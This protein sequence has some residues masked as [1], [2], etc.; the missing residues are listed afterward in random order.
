MTK[1]PPNQYTRRIYAQ[2][3]QY[4][5]RDQSPPNQ[6]TRRTSSP[7]QYTRR[8]YAQSDQ[9]RIATSHRQISTRGAHRLTYTITTLTLARRD[10]A[11]SPPNQYTAHI[12]TRRPVHASRKSPPNQ[13]TR[14]TSNETGHDNNTYA[15]P[16]GSHQSPATKN[17]DT[18][19]RHPRQSLMFKMPRRILPSTSASGTR[20]RVRTAQRT[21]ILPCYA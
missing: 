6:Y 3:D 7:N 21:A 20:H 10:R 19:I 5:H 14:S 16:T 17:T 4:T 15:P 1:S 13:Y 11:K 8:I 9:S 2:S 12:H 18:C